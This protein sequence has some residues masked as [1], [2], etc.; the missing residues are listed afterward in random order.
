[1]LTKLRV[2]DF[3]HVTCSEASVQT[4]PNK[5]RLDKVA[6]ICWR[7]QQRDTRWLGRVALKR[8]L[9]SACAVDEERGADC[10]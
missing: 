5:R 6:V 1:M 10:T 9:A 2:S 7:R 8:I 4:P 3:A